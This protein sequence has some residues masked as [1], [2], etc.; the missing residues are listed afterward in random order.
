MVHKLKR[1]MQLNIERAARIAREENVHVKCQKL[2]SYQIEGYFSP[3]PP[4]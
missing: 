2:E 4:P 1:K 3:T